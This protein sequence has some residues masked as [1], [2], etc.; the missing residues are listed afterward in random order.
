MKRAVTVLFFVMIY[1]AVSAQQFPFEF[2]HEGK[3]VLEEGD[4]LKGNIM[5][6]LQ[7]DLLQLESNN[8]LESY[9]ARKVVYFQIFD[10]TSK[11]YRQFYSLPYALAGAYRA[12]VF[13]ELLSEGKMTL[14]CREA[15]EYRSYP[16]TFYYYGTAT[17][18]V[19][20]Y[21]YFLLT[22]RG[23]IESFTGKK[24]DLLALMGNKGEQ[25][26]KF[27]KANKLNVDDRYE[28]TEIV[29]YYNSLF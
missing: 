5:Y 16:S 3:L 9:S 20:V 11:R 21:K 13:F 6:N 15:V 18:Q 27:M 25:V 28:F 23:E 4:T 10:R 1:A 24:N 26:E 22:E 8:R 29:D 19:L 17:R 2:W 7:N 12:P 14:L